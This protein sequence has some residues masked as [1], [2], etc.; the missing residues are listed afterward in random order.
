MSVLL[1]DNQI[2]TTVA[3]LP[4]WQIVAAES[5]ETGK[6]G[7]FKILDASLNQQPDAVALFLSAAAMGRSLGHFN[8]L[9]TIEFGELG[10][11]HYMF[12]PP[13]DGE[14][15]A[16]VLKEGEPIEEARAVKIV[17][18]VCA[19]LQ[20]THLSGI[21]HGALTP[22]NIFV[23][24][25]GEVRVTD[26]GLGKLLDFLYY[27]LK[28][29]SILPYALY[30]P[31]ERLTVANL[32][33]SNDL[34][35]VGV[36]FYHMLTGKCP[37]KSNN[38]KDLVR[39]KNRLLQSPRAVNP[40]ISLQTEKIL[41]RVLAPEDRA[42]ITNISH[43][44]HL[45]SPKP[46]E[47]EEPVEEIHRSESRIPPVILDFLDNIREKGRFFNATL[48][49]SQRRIFYTLFS[50]VIVIFVVVSIFIVSRISS[51]NSKRNQLLYQEFIAA[52]TKVQDPETI[53]TTEGA[54]GD[55]KTPVV[56]DSTAASP[57]GI[58]QTDEPSDSELVPAVREDTPPSQEDTL[59]AIYFSTLVVSAY[60]DSEKTEST[61]LIDGRRVGRTSSYAPLILP[62][63]QAEKSYRVTVQS[64][65]FEPWHRR[66]RVVVRDTNYV[67]AHLTPRKDVL[68]PIVFS[69]VEFADEISV[70]KGAKQKL[71]VTLELAP[72]SHQ[73]KYLNTQTG[74]FWETMA[75]IKAGG[76]N[77]IVFK[78]DQIGYGELSV[79]LAN[80][81]DYGY[82]FVIVDNTEG[83]QQT[84]P[85]RKKMLAGS[86][87]IRIFR[88]G[89]RAVPQDTTVEIPRNS[90]VN[91]TCKLY[92]E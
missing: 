55:Q 40:N 38:I 8:V 75:D 88:D 62:G 72:G 63:M 57:A 67:A 10:G 70:D 52:E 42:P 48:V 27:S 35:A 89:F 92:T 30:M 34:Y 81:A 91:V 22:E 60:A 71:P 45:L 39:E 61:V 77:N 56:A 15:L 43:F 49:G 5:E 44:I 83:Q 79:I 80:G 82:A 26:F 69:A 14:S 16:Y 54:D 3:Q 6:R 84:T 50:I 90:Q 66:V 51:E 36:I 20:F 41:M 21:L 7:W 64:E 13:F 31:S 73:L 68:S 76:E 85:L 74:Y 33:S 12:H 2:I 87:R 24:K 23:D 17:M 46:L 19:A 58:I 86:H 25:A 9:K 29:D 47:E 37:F 32:D 18:Q 4:F 11:M 65:G 1:G 53:N 78:P 59:P 28:K